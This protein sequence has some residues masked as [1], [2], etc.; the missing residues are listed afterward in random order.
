MSSFLVY[1]ASAGSG[2]TF[3]LAV[4]YIKLLVTAQA[5]AEYSR[6]LAVTFTNKATGEM[7][8]RIISQLYG[9]GNALPS[10]ENYMEAL[11]DSLMADGGE[12]LSDEQIRSRC[13]EAL[14]SILHDYN[15][16]RVQTIDSFFQSILRG[17]AH[18]L[19][20]AANL[21]V[22]ISDTEVLSR[23]VDRIVSRLQDDP[24]LLDWMMSLVR[25]QIEDNQRWDVTRQIKHFGRAIFDETYLLRGEK[26]RKVLANEELLRSLLHELN[27]QAEVI[28][29]A[30][31]GLGHGI[32]ELLEARG[33]TFTDF[34]NGKDL[35][36]FADKL[37]ACDLKINISARLQTWSFDPLTLVTKENQKK[38]P[39]LIA[40]ADD[41]SGLL[42]ETLENYA[43]L[44]CIANS[45]NLV[46]AHLKKLR[47][48]GN[49]DEEVAR[50][51]GE[52]NRF[53]LAKTPILLN[54]MIGESDAPFIFEKIGA[55]LHNVIIDEFQDTSRLQ[56]LNFKAL[57]LETIA[58]G[59]NNLIV[60]DV[61]QSI[62]RF[63][64]GDWRMLGHIENEIKPAP[65]IRQL[66]MNYR[67]LRNVVDFNN[68]FFERA[69][70]EMDIL[71]AGD[72]AINGV[73]FTFSQ[74]Y[75]DVHQF[76]PSNRPQ[77]GYVRLQLKDSK[78]YQRKEE[79]REEVVADLI[80]QVQMLHD[81]GLPYS[82][83]TILV[84]N[85]RES[86]IIVDA[87]ASNADLPPIVSDEA[88]LF[89][90]SHA[91]QT[92][93]CTL[94]CLLDANDTVSHFYLKLHFPDK[95][96]FSSEAYDQLLC[97]PLYELVEYLIGHFDLGAQQGQEAYLAAFM[98][99]LQDYLRNDSADIS[100]FLRYWD[101]RLAA[102][103]IAASSVEG[104]RI[105]TIHKSKGM[106]FHTVFIPFCAWKL[107]GDNYNDLIWCE[108]DE[109][110]Y[111][112][113]GL[114]PITPSAI[115]AKSV[116]AR[117]YAIEHLNTRL[118]E[119]NTLY[120]A[121]TRAR[122]NL[123]VWS[124]GNDDQLTKSM[125]TVGDLVAHLFPDGDCIGEPVVEIKSS[126]EKIDNRMQQT[127]LQEDVAFSSYELSAKFYQ[128]NRSE[129]FIES[130][131]SDD[132]AAS[133]ERA[134]QH[135]YIELGN[136][137]HSVLKDMRT[138]DDMSRVLDGLE[139]EGVITR[140]SFDGS[141]VSV[142]RKDIENWLA[143]GL[144]NPLVRDWFSGAWH[145]FNECAIL[146]RTDDNAGFL[147]H[148]PDRVMVSEDARRVVV[149]DYKFGSER[150]IYY[151]QVR[152]YMQLLQEMYPA[153]HVEGYLWFVYKGKVRKVD[154]K[155]PK[156]ED[157][158]QLNF[159]FFSN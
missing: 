141:Y 121:F 89:A 50:L 98:D 47:L 45:V 15:R 90:S 138:R 65:E 79:W 110:P 2:K 100:S 10:S 149:V 12:V 151:D 80:E 54:M 69:C 24:V 93:I 97:K 103:S 85:N 20:L 101:E 134:L 88:F 155:G 6:I 152:S 59:G 36:T 78:D 111:S 96:P 73:D 86:R 125:P 72:T 48:L 112:K 31:Q 131:L 71:F 84:R 113:F 53:N 57:L 107:E 142:S 42:A 13:R 145:L 9:I 8:D 75:S 40:V 3:T 76:V 147:N 140:T 37:C 102:Q 109:E 41:V 123:Y 49:I 23:A 157:D 18:E 156:R 21:Q 148:R 28:E 35:K 92:I 83:M 159:D 7:K 94:R 16:F 38:R 139:Q 60:G 67:S 115:A 132:E 144:D 26:L 99:A 33:V 114:V 29:P 119:L 58:K 61:K 118:D 22:E 136:L 130:L 108:P 11:R 126:E 137:L 4:H 14:H 44:Q 87:F 153:A 105:L 46:K 81:K 19:G 143:R 43:R 34:S 55:L 158:Q 154:E 5:P 135:Q 25:D 122:S 64:G 32:Y 128:S 70:K 66:D 133:S 116:F 1:K 17:L 74:A 77:T 39:E 124:C 120:V 56:W 150:G 106:E 95:F 127:R 129:Q 63:R 52:T 82:E 62:Y 104:I 68:D 30:L 27:E 91:I 51:N 117:D 146:N